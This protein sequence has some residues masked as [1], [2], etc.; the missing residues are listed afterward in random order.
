VLE[1]LEPTGIKD[2]MTPVAPSALI[3][4]QGTQPDEATVFFRIVGPDD[5][6]VMFDSSYCILSP[7]DSTPATFP[8]TRFT[9]FGRYTSACSVY[10]DGEQNNLNDKK[11]DTFEVAP[12]GV[13]DGS[14]IV[15]RLSF[16][17]TPNPATSGFVVLSFTGPLDHLTTGPL[18]LSLFNIS[19]RL[20]L[21]SSLATRNS[22]LRL[23]LRSM[24]AGV[25]VLRASAGTFTCSEKLVVQR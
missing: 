15:P 14:F 1:I 5:S 19:G 24:P 18:S 13:A 25:Y 17:V 7:G 10:V 4:N 12:V 11:I 2:T 23:D 20:V 9:R 22:S 16:S 3:K 8:E 21:H 6:V